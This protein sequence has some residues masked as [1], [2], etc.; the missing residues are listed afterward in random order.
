MDTR[1][2]LEGLTEA[3]AE[4]VTSPGAPL[5][6][7][8]GAGSGKTR[9]LTRRIAHRIAT[10]TAEPGR[11]LAITFTRK[12]AGE[13]GSRL[14]RLGVR[15]RVPTATF[16]AAAHAAMRRH[17]AD[18]GVTAP[19]LLE[20][21]GGLLARLLGSGLGSG[22]AD[23]HA[24][25]LAAEVEWAKARLVDPSGYEAA[26]AAAGR[27]P[28]LAPAVMATLYERYEAEKRRKGLVDFD[29]LLVRCAALFASDPAFA[30]R[31]RFRV[32]HLFVDE[33]QDV[34]PAQWAVLEGW[35]GGRPDL[36]VV[37]DPNQAIYAW[38]GADASI[39]TT[40]TD[41]FPD[42]TVVRLDDNFRSSPQVLV[43]ADA[44]LGA[45]GVPL[46][47][48]RDDGPVPTVRAYATDRDEA[49]GIARAVRDRRRP[50][51]WWSDIAV[52]A[53]TH[54]QL[55]IVEEALRAA[56]VPCLVRGAGAFLDRPEVTAAL[57][58]LTRTGQPFASWLEAL[59]A[60]VAADETASDVDGPAAERRASL[61]EL[62]RLGREFAAAAAEGAGTFPAWLAVTLRG[63]GAAAQ[64]RDAVELATF[65]AAKGLEWPVVFLAGLEKGLVPIGRAKDD[66]SVDEERR[67]LYVAVTRAER[68]LHCSWARTRTFGSRAVRREPSPWLPEIEA[69][70]AALLSPATGDLR[71]RVADE[72][73][74]LR[75]VPDAERGPQ[76]GQA[77]DPEVLTAL[78]DWRS[79]A[80]RAAGV[81]AY[82]IFHDTTLAA[83]AEAR[84]RDRDSLLAL[85]GLGPV[86][87]DRYGEELLDLISQIAS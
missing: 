19:A 66:A 42:A 24:G 85:P 86:K 61:V 12:A 11:V 82:V 59:D 37:G 68:E 70:R 15:E 25:D 77:A 84:P 63:E 75:A 18:T 41:R 78:K 57:Q 46:R 2:L 9:V 30:E 62:V 53:R 47:P 35:R 34:N 81:P 16:H 48:N 7:L 23:V 10:G 36:C 67:L 28:P 14:G 33:L 52:L 87:A 27:R 43:V 3:Q 72:R 1:A 13:L 39:L 32:R 22:A 4:A 6:I 79:K 54:V 40:F 83:V 29:D 56:G 26:V 45:A 80:A 64:G 8:A 55:V 51:T 71:A 20:R 49:T 31:E 21:K 76:V 69:A 38:N 65:H 5:C 17:W 60:R 44:V 74:R 73:R 58:D 50:G